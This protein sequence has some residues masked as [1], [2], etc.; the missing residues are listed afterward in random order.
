MAPVVGTAFVDVR[1]DLTGFG[2]EVQAGIRG[3]S[4][5]AETAGKNTGSRF[6][7]GLRT[8]LAGAV[9]VAAGNLLANFAQQGLAAVGSFVTGSI[10]AA[11]DLAETMS[12]TAV[13]F[14]D[15]SDAMVAWSQT[16]ATAFGLSQQE[17][18][19]SA[20]TFG[21]M[22][23]QLGFGQDQAAAMSQGIIKLAADLGS[24]HNV[25][26]TDMLDRMSAAFRGEYDSLQAVI[27]GINAARVEQEALAAT[28]KT[29]TD[30]LTQ[31][32][33]ALAIQAI[34]LQDGA[35][36]ADD[37]AETSGNLANQQRIAS[38]EIKN[39]QASLGQLL[40]PALAAVARVVTGTIIPAIQKFGDWMSKNKDVLLAVA[41]GITSVLVPAFVA[42]AVSAGAAALATIAAL[43]PF[44][45][46]G[47]AIAA[48]AF[49][50]IRNWDKVKSVA[51]T[52]FN[53]IR[54]AIGWV[55]DRFSF[56]GT[57]VGVVVNAVKTYVTLWWTVVSTA[58]R[59]I[60]QAI[61]W[62]ADK[63]QWIPTV[64]SA[65]VGLVRGYINLWV[66]AFDLIKGA[67][68][69]VF[70][71]VRDKVNAIVGVI[72]GVVGAI[73]SA[74]GRVVNAITAP[75]NAVIRAWNGLGFTM[76]R[77]EIPDWV[78]GIGG[79]G[80]GGFRVDFPNLPLLHAG[81]IVPG[82][83]GADVLAILRAGELVVPAGG[84][85]GPAVVIDQVVI[86]DPVDLDAFTARLS[87][88]V[89]AGR[90]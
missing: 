13:V 12:K 61:G 4:G 65:A 21:D 68:T 88:A 80:F 55:I 70:N 10:T 54:T 23:S 35:N 26:P 85:T 82:R 41:I 79:Q 45:A 49:L 84:R 83:P 6:G 71:W 19:A 72:S 76:P 15:Q 3:Q 50:I 57:V 2:R 28:G 32:D 43:A 16:A 29:S 7:A 89:V 22:F 36:A 59:Y 66:R 69:S 56:L 30:Q 67:A 25:D 39:A 27:P 44:I 31:M 52:V 8:G 60:I 18:L 62:V 42:W 64:V 37:F 51:A 17:A 90:L 38:A 75:I 47:A 9:T 78:P 74:V 11:S 24:F 20:S 48:A 73:Q 5:D 77:V 33:K 86:A 63:F 34:M 87:A 81:G 58:V 53:A 46:V 40:M 1:P 14:G